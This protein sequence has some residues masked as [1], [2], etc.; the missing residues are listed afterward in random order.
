MQAQEESSYIDKLEVRTFQFI[1]TIF[2]RM[3]QGVGE[4]KA[5]AEKFLFAE[6]IE[7]KHMYT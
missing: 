7:C 1:F 3:M 6:E 5:A 2:V 4:R